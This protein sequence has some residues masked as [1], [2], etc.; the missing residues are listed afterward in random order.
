VVLLPFSG[1]NG[2]L[3]GAIYR[4]IPI[5]TDILQYSLLRPDVRRLSPVIRTEAIEPPRAGILPH[6]PGAMNEKEGTAY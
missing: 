5:Y 4:Y 1:L 3:D 6:E 2:T